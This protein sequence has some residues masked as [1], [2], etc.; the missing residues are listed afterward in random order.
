LQS[1]ERSLMS[2]NMH[3]EIS[4]L[5]T[6]ILRH[7]KENLK[8][9]SLRGLE[10]LPGFEFL[11]YPLKGE[12]PSFAGYLMLDIDGPPLTQ[13]DA[14]R[15]LL[16]IDGTW[17]YAKKMCAFVEACGP[18]EKRS[19][20]GGFQTAYPRCQEDCPN[21][22]VGLASIEALYIAYWILNRDTSKL[23]DNYYWKDAFLEINRANGL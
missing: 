22:A 18:I 6:L 4:A 23:L 19:L 17:R 11:S 16:L 15:S 9:C 13:A 7:R 8:K 21:P 5:T 20:P 10:K 1:Y 3:S 2:T 14:G 12:V